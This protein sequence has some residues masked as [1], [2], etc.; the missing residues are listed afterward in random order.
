MTSI[1]RSVTQTSHITTIVLLDLEV[2]CKNNGKTS[3]LVNILDV[4]TINASETNEFSNN[5]THFNMHLL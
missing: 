3:N 1:K 4:R 5:L 2:K